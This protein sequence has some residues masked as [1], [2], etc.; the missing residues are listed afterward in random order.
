MS[1]HGKLSFRN[2]KK[3]VLDAFAFT[4]LEVSPTGLRDREK[5]DRM[6]FE[7]HHTDHRSRRGNAAVEY[8]IVLAL[9]AIAAIGTIGAVGRSARDSFSKINDAFSSVGVGSPRDGIKPA[10][11]SATHAIGSAGTG[12]P[13]AMPG[14]R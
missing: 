1:Q 10:P 2:G 3:Y 8:A 12:S 6:C 7:N 4:S 9:I 11:A 5:G 13:Q 14:L